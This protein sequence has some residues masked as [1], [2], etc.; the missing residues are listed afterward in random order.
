[1]DNNTQEFYNA[2]ILQALYEI[3]Q[4]TELDV[5]PIDCL[6]DISHKLQSIIDNKDD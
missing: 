3:K 1:V 6:Q 2:Y 4:R 5:L